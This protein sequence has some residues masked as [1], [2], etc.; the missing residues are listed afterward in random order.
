MLPTALLEI[1]DQ[2]IVFF[3]EAPPGCPTSLQDCV[4][5]RSGL[6]SQPDVLQEESGLFTFF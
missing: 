1:I 4:A 5:P 6:V 2:L 3:R